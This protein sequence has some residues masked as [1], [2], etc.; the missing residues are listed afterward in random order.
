MDK[1]TVTGFILI[2]LVIIG[3]SWYSRP[4]EAELRQ[5]A[6]QDSIA[7]VERAQAE[8]MEREQE[9][10]QTAPISARGA[11]SASARIGAV[12]DQTPVFKSRRNPL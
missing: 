1:N 8:T 3:F 9:T 10:E 11:P 12:S 4:S 7:A 5:Q 6:M 2:A